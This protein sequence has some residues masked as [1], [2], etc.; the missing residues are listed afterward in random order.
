[1]KSYN[2]HAE[3]PINP[4]ERTDE[5]WEKINRNSMRQEAI[6]ALGTVLSRLGELDFSFANIA[7]IGN[8]QAQLAREMED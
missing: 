8:I 7:K 3:P 1:M 5:E 6:E 2:Y 4:P